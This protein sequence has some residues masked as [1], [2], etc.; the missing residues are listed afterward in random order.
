MWQFDF[1]DPEGP[2]TGTV[3]LGPSNV[4]HLCEDPVVVVS[5]SKAL[6]LSLSNDVNSEVLILLDRSK[7]DFESDK[8]FAFSTPDGRVDIRWLD[9][10]PIN[11]KVL[12]KVML[13]T[14]PFLPSMKKRTSGFMEDDDGFN[15]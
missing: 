1:S 14:V 8:F 2:Q 13:V 12:A 11:C 5:E 7:Q 9:A 3:A 15:F 6:G 10:L 4:V